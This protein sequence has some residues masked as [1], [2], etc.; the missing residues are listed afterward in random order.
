MTTHMKR[1]EN[2]KKG[3]SKNDFKYLTF[4]IYDGDRRADGDADENDDYEPAAQVIIFSSL[5]LLKNSSYLEGIFSM[6]KPFRVRL[7]T[8]T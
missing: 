3:G 4:W 6:D 8:Y 5:T 7:R 1:G 2:I